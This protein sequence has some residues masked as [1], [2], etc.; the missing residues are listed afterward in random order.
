[1]AGTDL[2]ADDGWRS[3][4]CRR[5]WLWFIWFDKDTSLRYELCTVLKFKI[6]PGLM[7]VTEAG[8]RV[9]RSFD[10]LEINYL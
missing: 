6:R 5:S 2:D 1:M 8:A 4:L 9:R 3:C 7:S 10:G